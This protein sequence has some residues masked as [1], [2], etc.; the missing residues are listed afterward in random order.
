MAI[1]CPNCGAQL[2]DNARFCTTC[3]LQFTDEQ[4]QGKT[5]MFA[6]MNWPNSNGAQASPNSYSQQNWQNDYGRQTTQSSYPQQY[7]NSYQQYQNTYPQQQ[8]YGNSYSAQ[9]YQNTGPQQQQYGNSYSTQQYQNTGP[10][11]PYGYNYPPQQY[12][13]TGPQ[14]PYQNTSPQQPY[15]YNYPPQQYQNTYNTY[16]P[17][18]NNSSFRTRLQRLGKKKLIIIG[19]SA[20][21]AI[22]AVVILLVVLLGG[23]T[24]Y[25]I[26][27]VTGSDSA[28]ESD[29]DADYRAYASFEFK[30][31]RIIE[32]GTL[33]GSEVSDEIGKYNESTKKVTMINDHVYRFEKSGDKINPPAGIQTLTINGK[34]DIWGSWMTKSKSNYSSEDIVFD[35]ITKKKATDCTPDETKQSV[36]ITKIID[37]MTNNTIYSSGEWNTDEEDTLH[38]CTDARPKVGTISST[39]TGYDEDGNANEWT[40]TSSANFGTYELGTYT[41]SVAGTQVCSGSLGS[42]G[43]SITCPGVKTKP[44]TITVRVTDKAGYVGSASK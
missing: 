16:A 36:K 40:I 39:V 28:L 35:R 3:G 13:N 14:Q 31:G 21:A 8:Q 9:Q 5:T 22:A 44:G 19:S 12:Q 7:G 38:K 1:Q 18:Q 15:G 25:K 17:Q 37:P 23:S 29:F 32:S 33:L 6:G 4:Q 10:Q 27:Q 34:T 20:V 26:D 43:G 24:V 42:N 41:V 11:Q 30:D 2:S